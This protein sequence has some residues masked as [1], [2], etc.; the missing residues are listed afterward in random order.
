MISKM[1]E[2][3]EI[4]K[5]GNGIGEWVPGLSWRRL[6]RRRVATDGK[7]RVDKK[8]DEERRRRKKAFV[9]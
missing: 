7:E 4:K 3:L 9:F 1:Q 2:K 5:T 6:L 8:Y